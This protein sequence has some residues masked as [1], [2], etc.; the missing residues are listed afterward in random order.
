MSQDWE[1][2]REGILDNFEILYISLLD[3]TPEMTTSVIELILHKE[4]P[5]DENRRISCVEFPLDQWTW[6]FHLGDQVLN[7]RPEGSVIAHGDSE[8][9]FHIVPFLD[10]IA[11]VGLVLH[12][13]LGVQINLV[14]WN[15]AKATLRAPFFHVCLMIYC[16]RISLWILAMLVWGYL[17]AYVC[18]IGKIWENGVSNSQ[19][20]FANQY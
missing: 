6:I 19:I 20:Y 15:L 9:S 11:F 3:R 12:T 18:S 2:P 7:V 13:L 4:F 14:P 17:T 16:I 5:H 1:L 10:C 8:G